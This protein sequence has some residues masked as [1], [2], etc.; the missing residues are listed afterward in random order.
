MAIYRGS[1]AIKGYLAD[2][3]PLNIYKDNSKITGWHTE[4]LTGSSLSF[5]GITYNDVIDVE[6]AGNTVQSSDYYAKDGAVSQ[7]TDTKVMGKNLFNRELLE[8]GG[9]EATAGMYVDSNIRV[10]VKNIKVSPSTN[11]TLKNTGTFAKIR[12]IHA[13]DINK[14]WISILY[15]DSV[16]TNVSITTPT[17]CQYLSLS[18]CEPTTINNL[19][20]ANIYDESIQL[21]LGA[22]ATSF[23]PYKDTVKTG[24][25]MELSGRNFFNNPATTVLQDRSGNGNVGT[26]SGFAYTTASGSDG[27]GGI[28]FDGVND[29]IMTPYKININ[30]DFTLSVR[31]KYFG[32]STINRV[33]MYY[34]N[35]NTYAP[36]FHSIVAFYN[37]NT[38]ILSVGSFDGTSRM[39]NKDMVAG[40][41][42]EITLVK[43]SDGYLYVY[44]DGVFADS[45]LFGNPS[46]D[47]NAVVMIGE[48][49]ENYTFVKDTIY[50]ARV[51][52]RALSQ[53]EITQNYLA[54]TNLNIPSPT[55][56]SPVVSNLPANTYK[57]TSTDGIYEFVLPEELRGIG[58]T[59]DK[60]VFDRKSKVGYLE[61]RI[62]VITYNGTEDWTRHS[63]LSG[64]EV[65][66]F[67][68]TINGAYFSYTE[69]NC[70]SS[71]FI[72]NQSSSRGVYR[73]N[74]L[75][76]IFSGDSASPIVQILIKNSRLSSQDS[77]GFKSWLSAN[78][79]TVV[80]KLA[81]PVRTALT[82]TKVASSVRTEVPMTFLTATPSLDY[83]ASVFDVS[84]NTVKSR[85]KNLFNPQLLANCPIAT[86][87]TDGSVTL[88]GYLQWHY[89]FTVPLKAGTY[90]GSTNVAGLIHL[91]DIYGQA[92]QGDSMLEW[93]T[94][95]IPFDLLL[96]GY[97][98][99]STYDNVTLYLQIEEGTVATAYEPYQQPTT[100]TLPVLKKIGT[101]SDSY[102]PATGVKTKRISDWITLSG[103]LWW[104][105]ADKMING[106]R[107]VSALSNVD[108][109]NWNT[110]VK[111]TLLDYKT[112][113]YI[114]GDSYNTLSKFSV[115]LDSNVWL[116][117]PNVDTGFSDTVIPSSQ[118][119]K[120]YFYG[121]KMCNADG[122]S[123]YY[124][125]E[126]PYTAS[127]WA[128][129]NKL[130]AIS[131]VSGVTISGDGVNWNRI[132][133]IGTIKPTTKYGF[134]YNVI[135]ST[136]NSN[137][138]MGNDFNWTSIPKVTGNNKIVATSISNPA[139]NQ[140]VFQVANTTETG[141]IKLKDIR[142]FELPV[143][144]QIE[145][146][147]NTLTADQLVAKYTFNGLCAKNWKKV[148]DGTG[149]TATLPTASYS[150]YTPYK[151]LYQ[152]AT[153]VV[154]QLTPQPLPSYYPSTVVETDST[155]AIPVLTGT[156]KVED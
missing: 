57:Y 45:T 84:G 92:Q 121:W 118:E 107:V 78:P 139:N 138:L 44:F 112:S 27:A 105:N 103:D 75:E 153:P 7:Y 41:T 25:V 111:A 86:V 51:Y 17:N 12:N 154:T 145:T 20:P 58:S 128:E 23:E 8:Q 114:Y 47:A 108:T 127:T 3:K 72:G 15:G 93:S 5:A 152:L 40:T 31:T 110:E 130:G 65:S 37:R 137:C 50:S 71:K 67:Y 98:P 34:G 66:F 69:L 109:V 61:R 122:T 54:G 68:R 70:L 59:V 144:S 43:K 77:A 115:Y 63:T 143:G 96:T 52:N 155:V 49:N 151:M 150:G 18:F 11:Y 83:P 117:V 106:H 133:I 13:Y 36:A 90:K 38:N 26:P 99:A 82:F 16:G 88:N 1:Q 24:L 14:V 132:Y 104:T 22:T 42:I 74:N 124:K 116:N 142:I 48:S 147:F 64:T 79:V 148:T 100:A 97:I 30:N 73:D 136:F 119:W 95:V 149:Q 120:A 94:K 135:S 28:K 76:G 6:V 56:S 81:T 87:N 156:V 131:D 146:D 125:S 21:E 140:Y 134:L 126:V 32:L 2:R 46:I 101:V 62:G 129:W 4:T 80:Y 53:S 113:Q 35:G 85:G 91:F 60:V 102:N 29:K 89:M 39:I 55:D 141:S 9:I 19:I 33:I 123:P 10:R